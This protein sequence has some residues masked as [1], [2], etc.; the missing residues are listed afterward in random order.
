MQEYPVT[1]LHSNYKT[2]RPTIALFL[3]IT[4]LG[5]GPNTIHIRLLKNQIFVTK[6]FMS[7]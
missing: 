7:L 2:T 1:I 5:H 6:K 4:L 3:G